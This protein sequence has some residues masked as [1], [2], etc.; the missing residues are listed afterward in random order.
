MVEV[1]YENGIEDWNEGVE[2]TVP[3][4]NDVFNDNTVL[5]S[6]KSMKMDG[7]LNLDSRKIYKNHEKHHEYLNSTAVEEDDDTINPEWKTY[8]GHTVDHTKEDKTIG[9]EWAQ[10]EIM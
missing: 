5:P 3:T 9:T 8:I 10:A 2:L 6:V 7:H 1:K 4:R